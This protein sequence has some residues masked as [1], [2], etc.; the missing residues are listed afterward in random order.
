MAFC[1]IQPIQEQ[2]GSSSDQTE[3][4]LEKLKHR[5]A[6]AG[7]GAR[8]ATGR[9]FW[10]L[11]ACQGL[12]ATRWRSGQRPLLSCY[13]DLQLCWSA[14]RMQPLAMLP[15]LSAT[16]HTSVTLSRPTQPMP[17]MHTRP[18][19]SPPAPGLLHTQAAQQTEVLTKAW[20]RA[21]TTRHPQVKL[22]VTWIS[23]MGKKL[24]CLSPPEGNSLFWCHSNK[25][26]MKTLLMQALLLKCQEGHLF[27][28]R[29]T[30][31]N[32]PHGR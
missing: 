9:G 11:A 7:V 8:R 13:S 10:Q 30:P 22:R 19:S 21:T 20:C 26:A 14:T 29:D 16:A 24:L 23:E 18:V 31:R 4:G 25:S 17:V 27:S 32:T 5:E 6:L 2:R 3:L 1:P 28:E 15:W 12:R